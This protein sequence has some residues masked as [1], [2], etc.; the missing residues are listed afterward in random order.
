MPTRSRPI[1]QQLIHNGNGYKKAKKGTLTRQ[2]E[3]YFPA[4]MGVMARHLGQIGWG[5]FA[6]TDFAAGEVIV[7]LEPR[8]DPRVKLITAPHAYAT[9]DEYGYFISPHVFCTATET[10]PFRYLNHSCTANV[11]LRNWGRIEA[12]GVA[13]VAHR[14]I[15]RGE[16][17]T[18]DYATISTV[19]D[20]SLSGIVWFMSPCLCGSPAC[21]CAIHSFHQLPLQEQ[22]R[23]VLPS[24]AVSG[25]VL[26]HLLP[27]LEPVVTALREASPSLY[28]EYLEALHDQVGFSNTMIAAGKVLG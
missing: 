6:Q 15:V 11:G 26:A 5:L 10:H 23:A 28:R 12:D 20:N 4:E 16:Q 8:H 7:W 3:Q 25:K 21:R 14:E 27:Q 22:L 18:L 1:E 13:I 19:Y 17:L 9:N 24:D 2:T